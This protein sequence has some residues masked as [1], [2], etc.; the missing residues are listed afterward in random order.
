VGC[1]HG[2]LVRHEAFFQRHGEISVIYGNVS[3][4]IADELNGF[5]RAKN[6]MATIVEHEAEF[7]QA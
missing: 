4:N 7:S 3:E 2:A 1:N 5:D 6:F